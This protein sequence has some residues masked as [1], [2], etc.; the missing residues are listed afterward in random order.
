MGDPVLLS[1]F[2]FKGNI[3]SPAID[4]HVADGVDDA[5]QSPLGTPQRT[6][7]LHHVVDRELSRT[8]LLGKAG[9]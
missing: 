8:L 1:R 5:L 2:K 4:F 7:C 9:A 3:F 6:L